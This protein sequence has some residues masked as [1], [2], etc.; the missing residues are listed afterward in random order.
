MKRGFRVVGSLDPNVG[1]DGTRL[2]TEPPPLGEAVP[3]T[4]RGGTAWVQTSTQG[5]ARLFRDPLGI[6][7]LYWAASDPGDVAVAAR[8]K[9]L[10]DVGFRLSDVRS[11]PNGTIANVDPGGNVETASVRPR[12]WFEPS[13]PPDIGDIGRTIRAHMEAY[14]EAIRGAFDGSDTFICLSGGL[15]SSL[16]ALVAREIFPNITAVSFDLSRSGAD[17]S[18]DRKTAER[19]ARDLRLPLLLATVPTTDL[20]ANIDTVLVEGADW[21]DFNVHAGLVNAAIAT[22]IREAV[23]PSPRPVLVV[24]GDL[25]NEFLADYH[26]ETYGGTMHYR[27]PRLNAFSLRTWLVRGLDTSHREIG[28]FGAWGI[29]T[30][31]PYSVVVDEYMRL[32]GTFLERAERKQDLCRA[33]AGDGLPPYVYTRS[34]V[35]AQVGSEHG[36]G[37]LSVCIDKGITAGALKRRFA[38]LHDTEEGHLD[39][40]IRAGTY[41]SAVPGDR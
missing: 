21:R 26:E 22:T 8:P 18:D 39:R 27:L 34:K 16:V 31:Q 35:R 30:V 15:D 37:V 7:K 13:A 29:T 32:D 25:A 36:G 41:R 1:W 2:L 10:L 9:R 5:D 14:L 3:S 4:V 40:F 38:E 19:L 6:N 33:V 23:G 11:F 17:A 24:T 20:V 28:V 12:E